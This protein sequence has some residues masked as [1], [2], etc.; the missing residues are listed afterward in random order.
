MDSGVFYAMPNE[1]IAKEMSG[2]RESVDFSTEI[3]EL[4]ED[5]RELLNLVQML[6]S[7]VD[8]PA[9]G[10]EEEKDA[11]EFENRLGAMLEKHAGG[12]N[13]TKRTDAIE[14]EILPLV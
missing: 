10:S 13:S 6:A 2:G 8:F 11:I 5:V 1:D 9:S 14:G 3:R 7:F 4:K 12:P